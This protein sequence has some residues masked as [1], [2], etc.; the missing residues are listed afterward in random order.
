MKRA[1]AISFLFVLLFNLCGYRWV[2]DYLQQ[3]NDKNLVSQLDRQQYADEDLISIKTALSLP[4]YN[5][6]MEYERVD[7]SIR[8]YGVEYTYVKR[9]IVA[10]S[11]ELLCLPNT[12]K[13]K[14]QSAKVDF[15]K[16]TNDLQ[17]NDGQKKAVTILKTVVPDYCD[18]FP[19]YNF[20]LV[21]AGLPPHPVLPPPFL[22]SRF[23][24][25]QE[26][27]PETMRFFS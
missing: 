17:R 20:K 27:P 8:I 4:Y 13:Q 5:A 21:E 23:A 22:L 3:Q 25:V 11:L 7:G 19:Q 2:F 14:L 12:G 15:F 6:S 26:Q 24:N 18:A 1:T 10:D 9:R 16:I